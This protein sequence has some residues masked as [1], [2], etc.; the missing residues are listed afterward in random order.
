MYVDVVPNRSSPPAILLRES[1]REGNKIRKRTLANISHWE[2]HKVETLRRV[3]RDENLVGA[4]ELFRIEES[5]PHGHVMALLSTARR[6]GLQRAISPKG[7]R[8]RDLVMAMVCEQILHSGSKLAD[9]RLWHTSTLAQELG[10]QDAD[11]NELYGALDWLLSAQ[12]RIEG[13][14][15]AKHLKE[16]STV[17]YDVSSSYYEGSHCELARY[18]HNR[19]GKG[20]KAIIVYGVLT[21][22]EGRPVGVQVYAGNTGDP[23]TVIDQVGTL[24]ERFGLRRVVLVGDR[25]MLT[26]TQIDH[27]REY[28]GLGW[29]SA[30]RSS[31]IAKL[32]EDGEL[33]R[34]LF[35]RENLAEISSSLYPGERLVA[36]FNPLLAVERRR[37]RDELLDAT[38]R[39]IE[40]IAAEVARRTKTPLKQKEIALKVGPKINKWKVAKHFKLHIQDGKLE[41]S[42]KS[43]SIERER[44]LDG[45]YIVR[46]CESEHSL[47]SADAVRQYKNLSRVERLFRTCKGV[48]ILIRPIRHR[49]ER[50]VRAHIF[51]CML[52]YYL[53]WHLRQALAPLLYHDQELDSLR[54]KR[55]PV[56][57]AEPSPSARRKKKEK[58]TA[59]GLPLH[60]FP[61]L[62]QAL[63]TLCRNRCVFDSGGHQ[64]SLI[65]L[66]EPN[67]LQ[68]RAFQLLEIKEPYPVRSTT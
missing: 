48:D 51:L 45:I 63:G 3:L 8:E 23:S 18:G 64:S 56:A 47:S 20:G 39:A 37:K 34:E 68:R 58:T 53:E 14:L 25:G 35:D 60:S 19:D 57:K 59:E 32:M 26:E 15:A 42:R 13:R 52:A 27:L 31:S 9:T 67:R 46:T 28:P 66:T 2:P 1:Y 36:C 43:E 5:L 38:E 41:W 65:K 50:R 16:G 54:A 10:V 4:D 49:A 40:R 17:F 29:I 33:S 30:L 6:I 55:D 11:E 21:D 61:D 24:R 7:S 62:L 12:E 44:Q 22:Q